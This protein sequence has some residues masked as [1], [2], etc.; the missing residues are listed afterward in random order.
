MEFKAAADAPKL[1]EALRTIDGLAE[2]QIQ[3][4]VHIEVAHAKLWT[5]SDENLS[6]KWREKCT[7]AFVDDFLLRRIDRYPFESVWLQ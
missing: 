4:I 7:V 6:N 5:T 2:E 1:V 3:A